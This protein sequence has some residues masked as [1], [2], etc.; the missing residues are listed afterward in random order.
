MAQINVEVIRVDVESKGKYQA[1]DVIY[2]GPEG[3]AHTK[4]LVSFSNKE[5][6]KL[7]SEAQPGDL[8]QVNSEK[9]ENGYWQWVAAVAV[10][11]NTGGAASP[12]VGKASPKSTYE[13]SEERA[14]RQV[15]IVRQSSLSSAIA[16]LK[17]AKHTPSVEEVL[18][19]AKQFERAIFQQDKLPDPEV[20]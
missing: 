15:L 10:G 5:V 13:T 6:F 7:L 4:K 11:K 19:V 20:I 16:L 18:D 9:D 8:F 3:K 14:F 12:V 17:D 1:A 2:K